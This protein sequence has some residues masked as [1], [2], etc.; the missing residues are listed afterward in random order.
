MDIYQAWRSS[1]SIW[2]GKWRIFK[3]V[4]DRANEQQWTDWTVNESVIWDSTEET[5]G[6]RWRIRD[7]SHV[8]GNYEE[9][10]DWK[11][12][13]CENQDQLHRQVL[14]ENRER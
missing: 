13:K 6:W 9:R 7:Q 4:G 3:Q 10:T 2:T 1:K 12:G 5:T 14:Q 8:V 11:I